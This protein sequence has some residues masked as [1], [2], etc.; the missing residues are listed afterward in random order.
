MARYIA[1]GTRWAAP[2][3]VCI[4]GEPGAGKTRLSATFPAPF[5]LDLESGSHS[6]R[7]DGVNRVEIETDAGAV[8]TVREVIKRL[9]DS[10]FDKETRRVSSGRCRTSNPSLLEPS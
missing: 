4:M 5:F 7:P 1:R 6:A 9:K 8:A 10:P 2:Q 3:R